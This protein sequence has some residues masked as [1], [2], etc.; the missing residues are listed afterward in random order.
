MLVAFLGVPPRSFNWTF[1]NK[2]KKISTIKN[3]DPNKFLTMTKF[4]PDDWVS[5]INDPR[6][7]NPYNNYYQVKYLG[8]VHNKHVGWL[9]LNMDRLNQLTKESI[10]KKHPVWF[11]CDVG[12]EWDRSSGVE[13]PGIIDMKGVIGLE[14]NQDKE[15]RLSTFTSLPNHAM[16]IT[17]YHYDDDNVKRWKVE[18]SWGKDSGS[19]GFLLMTSEWMNQYVFQILVNKELLRKSEIDM[20]EMDPKVIEPWDPLGTLA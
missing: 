2:D 16:L 6:K 17:G 1:K 13:H 10:D 18:N 8:N 14:T 9:N 15:S 4:D 3:L 20:L 11:G 19:N 7:E 5:I 12:A